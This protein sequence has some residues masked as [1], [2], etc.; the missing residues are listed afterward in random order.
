VYNEKIYKNFQKK[1]DELHTHLLFRPRLDH[2]IDC[3]TLES[4]YHYRL[5]AITITV[6]EKSI[7]GIGIINQ[8][9]IQDPQNAN[10][11]HSY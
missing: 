6:Y 7:N 8:S 2:T 9:L 10:Q 11:G 5:K 1:H 4:Y 3:I